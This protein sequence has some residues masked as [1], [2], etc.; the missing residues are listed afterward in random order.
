ME[1]DVTS[2]GRQDADA[3][4]GKTL[5]EI[6]VGFAF[7]TQVQ[8]ANGKGTKRLT[9]RTF[10]FDARDTTPVGSII[11]MFICIPEGAG[12]LFS[13]N[14]PLTVN[15]TPD[16]TDEGTF[17]KFNLGAMLVIVFDFENS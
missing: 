10:E 1:V 8:T 16:S 5:A 14:K 4:T 12:L 15:L 6:V 7:Q 3:T 11:I 2:C 9:C 17:T 13:K